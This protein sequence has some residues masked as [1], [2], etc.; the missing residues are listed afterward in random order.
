MLF[1][2]NHPPCFIE[3]GTLL[4]TDLLLERDTRTTATD[5]RQ[6]SAGVLLFQLESGREHG[7]RQS[8]FGTW[9]SS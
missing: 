7:S 5:E 8:G 6:D 2:R 1:L 9:R 3:T 4:T